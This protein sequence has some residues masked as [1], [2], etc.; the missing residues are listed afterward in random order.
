MADGVGRPQT[1]N[2][3]GLTRLTVEN[4]SIEYQ[5]FLPGVANPHKKTTALKSLVRVPSRHF[6]TTHTKSLACTAW[7]LEQNGAAP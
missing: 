3:K 5:G 6:K 2:S 1:S 7:S 4:C